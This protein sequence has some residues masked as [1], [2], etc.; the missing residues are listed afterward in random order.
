VPPASQGVIRA[1][2]QPRKIFESEEDMR[3]VG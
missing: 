2:I 1:G 3:M